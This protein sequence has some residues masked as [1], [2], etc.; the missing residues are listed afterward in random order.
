MLKK[1]KIVATVGPSTTEKE[2]LLKMIQ[3]GVNV[4]RINFSHGTYDDHIAAIK[5]IKAA[6]GELGTHTAIL[7][8]LQGPKIRIGAMP[9]EGLMLSNGDEFILTNSEK[10]RTKLSAFISYKGLPSDVKKGEKILLDDGK[11]V[12]ETIHTDKKTTITTKVIAGG[13][14]YSRK[15]VNLPDTVIST[16]SLT[17]KDKADLEVALNNN[18]DWVGFSFVRNA[19]EIIELRHLITQHGGNAKIIAKI[20]KPEAVENLEAIIEES[21]AIMVARGDHGVEVPL[22]KVPL[23]QKKIVTHS[24]Q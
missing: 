20:E 21:D 6:D 16:S 9:E 19:R 18:V 14:L 22:E 3:E 13:L 15:G 10:K 5:K 4:F 7:A 12:L 1:T 17:E 24:R 8:D 2:T 11:I 23:L